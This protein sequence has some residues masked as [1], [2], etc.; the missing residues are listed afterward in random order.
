MQNLGENLNKK[1]SGT[2]I[3]FKTQ[4]PCGDFAQ[5]ENRGIMAIEA[6]SKI[7]FA[8]IKMADMLGFDPNEIIGRSLFDFLDKDRGQV[9]FNTVQSLKAG[10]VRQEEI[11]FLKK[12]GTSLWVKCNISMATD[13]QGNPCGAIIFDT[14]IE[15]IQ[16]VTEN[17]ELSIDHIP[18]PIFVQDKNFTMLKINKAGLEMFNVK[19][20]DVIGKKCFQ[21]FHKT[22]CPWKNCPFEKT[23]I[24]LQ[25]H[26]EKIY[27]PGIGK[28]LLVTT[29]P[30][31]SDRNELLGVVHIAKDITKQKNIEAE[32]RRLA[33]F[34]DLNVN[35]IFEA[36]KKG[37]ILYQN[38]ALK[39]LF[40]DLFVKGTSHP[41]MN[42]WESVIENLLLAPDQIISRQITAGNYTYLQKIHYLPDQNRVRI[43]ATDITKEKDKENRLQRL[44]RTLVALSNSN[45]LLTRATDEISYLKDVCKIVTDTCGHK[46][47]W[48]GYAQDDKEKSI[49]LMAYAGFDE[50]YLETLKLTWADAERGRGPTGTAIREGKITICQNMLEDPRFKPWREEAV[51]RGYASSIAL[52]LVDAEKAFGA[53]AIYSKKINAF[54]K[55]EIIL[56]KELSS[57]VAYGIISLRNRKAKEETEDLFKENQAKLLKEKN[58]FNIIMQNTKTSLTYLDRD[59]NF[60]AVNDI[61]C[62]N[63]GRTR[64]ELIGRNYFD[65]FPNEET[66]LLFEKVRDTGK[67]IELIQKPLIQKNQ[68]W[69]EITYWDWTIT[70]VMNNENYA[71]GLVVALNDVSE[72]VKSIENLKLHSQKIEQATVE[73]KKVQTAVENASD[74]IFIT[75]EKGKIIYI[76]KAVKNI[77]GYKQK[78]LIGKKPN[79]WMED[80]P[81]KFFSQ[82]W[83]AIYFSKKPFVGEIKDRKKD[84]DVFTA[85]IRIAP[86]LDKNN[87]ILSF[88]GIERDITEAKRLNEA[89]T[90]FISLAAHQLRTPITNINLTAEMLIDGLAGKLDKESDG[91]LNDIMI[92]IQK[93]SEMIELFLNVSR[94]EMKTFKFTPQPCNIS[95]IIEEN[96][97]LILPQTNSRELEIKKNIPQ[98]LPIIMIDPKAMNI[99]LENLLS[100]AIKYTPSK[101]MIKVEAERYRDN[102]IIKI[103]DTGC[104]IPKNQQRKIFDKLYR[105]ENTSQKIEGVGLGLFLV[106]SLVEQAGGKL[107]LKSEI[108]KGSSFYVSIPIKIK[109]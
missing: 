109:K 56:L 89:K 60:I 95:Q 105:V 62:Q 83:S 59:F 11:K 80:M 42:N 6:G 9:T 8:N 41:W 69:K 45:Q 68:P 92:G 39:N 21:V 12:D 71:D 82:M 54:S 13:K 79:F 84:G 78:E 64:E 47:I 107:W 97:K 76:N 70:P 77:L 91:Y 55:D 94:I 87:Q 24:D 73:L 90:E 96:V 86:V 85:E 50:G 7:T 22:D 36:D 16:S 58:T 53:I 61:Y 102:I 98:D 19:E 48:I 75:D 26:T 4:N 14:E 28:I 32:L 81:N 17:W 25:K 99:V 51:K 100:N 34:P 3:A 1:E 106:K 40:P 108:N 72:R 46:M 15:D 37:N 103:S 44:N 67:Q 31:L 66:R 23:R 52:P 20:E 2:Q 27:D 74:I 30:I 5:K 65:F 49:K 29:S 38:P 10:A 35:P 101:G 93:M 18:D 63:N 57:D 33:S 43:Y 88:V 104:G